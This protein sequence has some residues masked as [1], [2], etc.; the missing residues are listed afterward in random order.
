MNFWGTVLEDL[1][2]HFQES[3]ILYIKLIKTAQVLYIIYQTATQHNQH[4]SQWYCDERLNEK[5]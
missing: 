3:K 5:L 4:E 2:M 1:I